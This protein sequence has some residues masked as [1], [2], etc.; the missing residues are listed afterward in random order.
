M[1]VIFCAYLVNCDHAIPPTLIAIFIILELL[2]RLLTLTIVFHCHYYFNDIIV[3]VVPPYSGGR[4]VLTRAQLGHVE[5]RHGGAASRQHQL[6]A[7][8]AHD[9]ARHHGR[10]R[11][12]SAVVS[13]SQ[14]TTII[15]VHFRTLFYFCEQ[16][17]VRILMGL[18]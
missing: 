10:Y 2:L 8:P 9:R 17:L 6:P 3:I 18:Q 14:S 7:P 12:H 5:Q 13:V 4:A 1:H 16:G 15:T 11:L